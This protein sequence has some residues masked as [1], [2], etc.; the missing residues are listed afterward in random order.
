MCS[1]QPMTYLLRLSRSVTEVRRRN[2]IHHAVFLMWYKEVTAETGI[3]EAR[4][5]LKTRLQGILESQK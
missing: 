2:L 4:Q 1:M 5:P 3:A